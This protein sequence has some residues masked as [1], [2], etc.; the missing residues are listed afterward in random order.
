MAATALRAARRRKASFRISLLAVLVCVGATSQPPA[1]QAAVPEPTR[2]EATFLARIADARASHD[3]PAYRVGSTITE[4]ARE[5]ALRMAKR[6]TLYHN[7]ELTSDVS[8]WRYLGENVGYG[9]DALTV[10]RAF[11][12]SAPHRA[13]ILDRDYTRVG[14]GAVVRNGRVWVCEVF[15]TPQ[16]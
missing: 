14:V 1:A 7:P 6:N 2:V 13:N 4:V 12:H 5:Q 10:H 3:L 16:T 8:N 15:K 11:M 9:P